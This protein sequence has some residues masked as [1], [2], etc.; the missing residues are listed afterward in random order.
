VMTLRARAAPCIT[1]PG[2]GASV[3]KICEL[4][5]KLCLYDPCRC[6]PRTRRARAASGPRAAQ[7]ARCAQADLMQAPR[8]TA[9][10]PCI[11]GFPWIRGFGPIDAL[12]QLTYD[13]GSLTLGQLTRRLPRRSRKQGAG[14]MSK[15]VLKVVGY[16]RVSTEE[17]AGT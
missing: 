16:A 9:D 6:V 7:S 17:Q 2:P 5:I 3:T 4:C 8:E 13:E 14:A 15:D 11:Q 12:G 10:R 1:G